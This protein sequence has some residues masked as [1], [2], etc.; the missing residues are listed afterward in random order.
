MEH[1]KP[2]LVKQQDSLKQQTSLQQPNALERQRTDVQKD[3]D[4]VS[5]I[6]IHTEMVTTGTQTDL[7]FATVGIQ[8]DKVKPQMVDVGI[9]VILEEEISDDSMLNA[10]HLDTARSD[11]DSSRG[12]KRKACDLVS[13][14]LNKPINKRKRRVSY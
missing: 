11:C 2:P 10:S 1:E 6:C 14:D 8:V 12:S 9:Q 7:E 13:V 3:L 4:N 5:A